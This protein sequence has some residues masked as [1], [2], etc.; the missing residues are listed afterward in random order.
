MG[1]EEIDSEVHHE[2]QITPHT[3]PAIPQGHLDLDEEV[4]SKRQSDFK[5]L[6]A[7]LS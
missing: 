3:A 5:F 6:Y 1:K 7:N 2:D 4:C